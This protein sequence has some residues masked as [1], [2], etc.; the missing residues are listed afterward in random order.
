MIGLV[1]WLDRGLRYICKKS[2][3]MCICLRP[4]F[5]CPEVTLCGWQDINIQLL[6]LLLP[7][8][9]I[10]SVQ[11]TITNFIKKWTQEAIWSLQ[12]CFDCTDWATFSESC[13]NCRHSYLLCQFLYRLLH[14][15]KDVTIYANDKPWFS[16]NIKHKLTAK[17]DA[18]K[19]SD[20][21]QYKAA[22]YEA[23]K[24]IRRAKSQYRNKLEKQFSTSNS[25][26]V[27]Q[28]LQ[29]ITQYKQKSTPANNDPTLPDQLNH[30]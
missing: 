25:H 23:E 5:D 2:L 30:L 15:L 17:N 13:A 1:D 9:I 6:L 8:H 4:E 29:R 22:K 28:G 19:N 21:N 24:A 26:A 12:G 18:F 3:E 14:P 20:K 16:K 11:Y 7:Q 27:W 10:R